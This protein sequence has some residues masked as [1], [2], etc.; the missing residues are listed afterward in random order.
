MK[1]TMRTALAL[2]LALALLLAAGCAAGSAK[3]ADYSV[4]VSTHS[5]GT[6]AANEAMTGGEIASADMAEMPEPEEE[7]EG[8]AGTLLGDDLPADGRK[9]IRNASV[10]IETTDFEKTLDAVR[11]GAREAEGYVESSSLYTPNGD[12]SADLTL[13][14][15]A[16]NYSAFLA[17]LGEAG[18][19]TRTEESTEDVTTQHIDVTARLKS[20]KAQE[21]RLLALLEE[22]GTLEELIALQDRLSDV[23][24]QIESYTAQLEALD[25]RID[26]ATVRVWIE[27]VR[28]Y[29]PIEPNFGERVG[30]AFRDM[31]ESIGDG[32]EGFVLW[33]IRALPSLVIL[34]VIVLLIVWIVKRSVR[35]SRARRAPYTPP[36][37]PESP[38]GDPNP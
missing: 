27:E 24:Y 11:N 8:G 7:A 13:R 5:A 32:A 25:D 26:Y 31:V 29:T 1:K 22:S 16:A 34:A 2:V 14:I 4:S 10:D 28:R 23:Q 19:V 38:H 18:S 17:A 15:P 9:I 3:S 33:L 21:E 35:R 20:L 36:A 6:E 37:P 30:E 12:R